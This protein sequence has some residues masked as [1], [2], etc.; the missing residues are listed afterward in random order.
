DY[1][2]RILAAQAL[3]E[4]N[5]DEPLD[6]AA[7]ARA[8]SFSLH[9]FH[10]IFRALVGESAMEH[11]RRLR[12]ERAARKLRAAGEARIVDLALE[13]GYESHEA[14]TRAFASRFGESPSSF[15]ERP[16]AV[17]E[18]WRRLAPS[19]PAVPVREASFAPL[20]VA[21]MRARGS[22]AEV[23]RT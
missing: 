15:R 13:A 16:Q 23:G 1:R 21:F 6:P 20:R 3:L 11:V 2:R 7:L 8:A 9:H 12:L 10:R 4:Q 5:L 18:E 14:F 19:L 17:L 22:Y